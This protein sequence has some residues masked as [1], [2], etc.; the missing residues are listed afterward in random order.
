AVVLSGCGFKDGTEITESICTLIALSQKGVQYKIFAP[1]IEFKSKNHLNGHI[2][3]VRNV[4]VESARIARGEIQDLTELRASDFDAIVFPGGYGAAIHLCDWA[5]KGHHCAVHPEAERVIKE[6]NADSCPIGAICIAPALIARV[7]GH[8]NIT[9]TIGND[10]ETAQEIAATGAIHEN[11]A[12][13][14]FI[15]D[16]ENK[17]I[18]TPAYMYPAKPAEVFKGISGLIN[19]L[20]EMA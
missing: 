14:D 1:N 9:L 2:E 4:L 19:E 13:D 15:T 3:G 11:C 7:L 17:I 5:E 12:V 18:S 16:R 20:V 8:K 6:F 10:K